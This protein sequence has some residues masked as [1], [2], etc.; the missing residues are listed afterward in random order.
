MFAEAIPGTSEEK[1]PFDHLWADVEYAEHLR[2]L[3][4]AGSIGSAEIFP[5]VLGATAGGPVTVVSR[6]GRGRVCQR[7]KA[8]SCPVA[9]WQ[10]SISSRVLAVVLSAGSVRQRPDWGLTS[11]PSDVDCHCCDAVPLQT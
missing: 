11:C 8:Q 3:A 9:C 1:N 6:A 7:G 10:S 5:T 2:H 4:A